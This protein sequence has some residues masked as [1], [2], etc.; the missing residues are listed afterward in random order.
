MR[1][2]DV[3]IVVGDPRCLTLLGETMLVVHLKMLTLEGLWRFSGGS[4]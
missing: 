3:V 1:I 2:G 4:T